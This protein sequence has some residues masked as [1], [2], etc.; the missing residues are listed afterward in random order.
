MREVNFLV[1]ARTDNLVGFR[2]YSSFNA[3]V[4]DFKKGIE[5]SRKGKIYDEETKL[6]I[7]AR[8]QKS[9]HFTF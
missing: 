6:N 7:Q 9:L 1:L 2:S 8:R 5:F 4:L 3:P